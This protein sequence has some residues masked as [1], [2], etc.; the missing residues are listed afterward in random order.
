[1]AWLG[2]FASYV[3]S[4]DTCQRVKPSTQVRASLFQ[5]LPIVDKKWESVSLDFIV[6]LPKIPSGFD[7]ILVVI[8][9][10]SKMAHFIPNHTNASGP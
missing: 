1:M 3:R 2:M 9:R 7:A 6:D 5:P 4:C 10:L 8:D